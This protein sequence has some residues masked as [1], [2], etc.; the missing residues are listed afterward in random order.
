VFL[1]GRRSVSRR[2]RA[3]LLGGRGIG[4]SPPRRFTPGCTRG[5]TPSGG[6][7][8]QEARTLGARRCLLAMLISVLASASLSAFS[9][10]HAVLER[11]E[12]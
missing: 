5:I 8:M 6:G 9:L 1:S 12:R 2:V 11:G 4:S 7:L 10:H 3:T